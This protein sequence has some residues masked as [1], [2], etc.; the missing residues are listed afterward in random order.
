VAATRGGAARVALVTTAADT[1]GQ[2]SCNPAIGGIAKGTV[3]RE[4]DALGGV[5][6]RATDRAAIQFRMLNRGKGPAVWAPRSQCDRRRYRLAVQE[7]V[8]EHAGVSVVAATVDALLLTP[9]GAVAGVVTSAGAQLIAKSVVIATGTFLRGRICIGTDVQTPGG[10][11]GEP[12]TTTLAEQL[13]AIGLVTDRFKTGTPPRIDGRTVNYAGL[14]R[15]DSERDL[16]AFRWSLVGSAP[17]L[18]E[19]PCWLAWTTATTHEIVHA[20]SAQSAMYGGVIAAR[21]PRYCPSIE[22]KVVRFPTATR[23]QVFLEPEGLDTPELYVNGLSTSLPVHAQRTML[24]SVPG[25]DHVEMTKPGYAIEYDYYDPTQ[26]FPWL[27]SR[28]VAG[29]FFAGQ[30]NGT[31]GY[32][33][34]AGQGVVA[35]VNAGRRAAGLDPVV[36]PRADSYIGVLTDDLVTRGVDEPYRLFTSRS[37]FRLTVRQDNAISRLYPFAISLGLLT[38]TE[39]RAF[40]AR[41]QDEADLHRLARETSVTPAVIAPVLGAAGYGPLPHA[42]RANDLVKRN[43]VHLRDVLDAAGTTYPDDDDALTTVE[44]EIKYAGYFARERESATRLESLAAFR[45][46]DE[47]P[48]EQ[49][50]S[51]SIEARSKLARRRPVTLAQAA[52]IPGVSPADLQNLVLEVQRL[53]VSE[54]VARD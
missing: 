31:T 13:A 23:H 6:A 36:F 11:A 42:V 10:R 24:R 1:I 51:L 5:M 12:P 20:H 37:E 45:L 2:M 44:L 29:L 22:D 15:Q 48:Y 3:V 16:H 53:R 19:V 25:L 54:P 52:S 30:V 26:L 7:V 39:R 49:M 17:P 35:G 33:E 9:A 38:D 50:R 43:G 4:V 14:Q 41:L 18:P 34:A 47:A 8:R 21:G 46:P 27:E 40:D 32:E 28:A